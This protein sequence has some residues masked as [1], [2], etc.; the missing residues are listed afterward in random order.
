MEGSF[1]PE[2][3]SGE[4]ET[5][6]DM[7]GRNTGQGSEDEI[8]KAVVHVGRMMALAARTAP[9]GVGH[10]HLEIRLVTGDDVD[11]MGNAMMAKG[12]AEGKAHFIRDGK[13][14]LRC[15]AVL[16]IGLLDHPAMGLDCGG[17][18][19][20][21]CAAFEA[22]REEAP[23]GEFEPACVFRSQDLGIAVGS[24]VKTAQIHNVDNRVMYRAAVI[25]IQLGLIGPGLCL[26][27]PL[28]AVGKSPFFDR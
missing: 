4:G 7:G 3:M 23:P 5:M 24:A 22:A 12:E 25:G 8:E 13:S 14:V 20:G 28:A 19:H 1:T 21:D 2:V 26:G 15:H 6:S 10:D 16:L 18:G 9:K 17:C 11:R 27:I